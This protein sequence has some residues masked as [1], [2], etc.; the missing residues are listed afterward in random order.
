MEA[1]QSPHPASTHSICKLCPVLADSVPTL[2][3]EDDHDMGLGLQNLTQSLFGA[4]GANGGAGGEIHQC[5][6]W[7]QSVRV[8]HFPAA[9][10]AGRVYSSKATKPPAIGSRRKPRSSASAVTRATVRP[11]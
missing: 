9:I 2:G 5:Q 4:I 6:P 7:D 11:A 3:F 8:D 1:G 10:P